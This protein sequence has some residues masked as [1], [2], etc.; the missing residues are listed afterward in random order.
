MGL[1]DYFHEPF[2]SSLLTA[3]N[4]NQK[5]LSSVMFGPRI[6]DFGIPHL[7]VQVPNS[8][9]LTKNL[10]YNQYYTKP[11]YLIVNASARPPRLAG[12]PTVGACNYRYTGI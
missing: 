10:Y 3:L 5:P 8:H 2:L 9:V 11:K 7:R 1:Q 12:L 6:Q 4:L